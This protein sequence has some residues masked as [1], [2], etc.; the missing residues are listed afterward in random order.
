[1]QSEI[2]R[3]FI[4]KSTERAKPLQASLELTYRCNERCSHCYIEEFRDDPRRILDLQGWQKVLHELR[5]GGTLFVILMGGEPLLSPLFFDIANYGRDLGFHMSIISNGLKIK[6]IDYAKRMKDSGIRLATF[7]LYSMDPLIH[8]KMTRVRGSHEKLLQAID[9]CQ[10][11]GIEVSINSLLC[12]AN[13]RGIFDLYDWCVERGFEMK[14]DPNV[15]PKLNGDLEPIQFRASRETLLWFYRER[16]TRWRA[17]LPTPSLETKED[18]VCNA[19]KGKCAVT[20]YGELLPCIE[21]REPM[22]SLVDNSFENIWA[23]KTAEKWRTPR[24]GD[25]KNNE[26]ME[27]YSFCDHCPGMAKNEHG[28]PLRVSNYTKLVADVKRQVYQ[29]MQY[30]SESK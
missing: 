7:S 24:I 11:V 16:A 1:M 8:D 19:A 20:A 2:F 6:N 26:D 3:K 4:R 13:S 9:F 15:T 10:E 30:V 25:I 27:L 12:E 22:G 14:V 21:I 18:Y 29:E 17:S 28:D 23:G 5:D